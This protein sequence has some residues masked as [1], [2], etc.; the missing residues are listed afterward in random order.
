MPVVFKR[1]ALASQPP[2]GAVT[3]SDYGRN[4]L[5]II[6]CWPR[7]WE[8][9][10]NNTNDGYGQLT[11]IS[12]TQ[13]HLVQTGG[14]SNFPG[15]YTSQ[16]APIGMP[17]IDVDAASTSPR[18]RSST[19]TDLTRAG[20]VTFGL[21][22]SRQT[23]SSSPQQIIGCAASGETEATN[24]QYLLD[25]NSFSYNL[26]YF[27]EYGA[28]VNQFSST[29]TLPAGLHRVVCTRD[30]VSK[31]V[32]VYVDGVVRITYNYTTNPTGGSSAQFFLSG[33]SS[34]FPADVGFATPFVSNRVWTPEQVI[35]DYNQATRWTMFSG[36]PSIGFLPIAEGRIMSSLA[37]YGG[38]AGL[39]G[40]AGIKGGL[41]G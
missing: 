32:L 8:L 41:A 21:W 7:W 16:S 5:G 20:D 24:T 9:G 2:L 6:G 30:A 31:Q 27:H 22:I 23:Q 14:S 17:L 11:D 36:A 10:R 29:Y 37:N 4:D 26:R 19:G 13:A 1:H 12:D 39:G 15:W 38:L 34:S 40:L 3:L 33:T 35:K 28:G 18:I 25:F